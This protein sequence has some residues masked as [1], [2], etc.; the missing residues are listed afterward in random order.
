[1]RN[2]E[3]SEIGERQKLR[4]AT[5]RSTL[6][7]ATWQRCRVHV[8]RDVLAHVPKTA[9][10]MVAAFSRTVF[11]QPD[12]ASAHAQLGQVVERLAPS[13]PKAAATLLAEYPLSGRVRLV[14]L[15]ASGFVP[16]ETPVQIGLFCGGEVKDE[17][18]EK[19]D[20]AL[21]S[22]TEKFG[23][24]SVQRARLAPDAEPPKD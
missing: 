5:I 11:A 19:V 1:M 14:G 10:A 22:I 24:S 2:R 16:E 23:R 9:Q 12:P 17:N 20:R 6:L 8:L 7:G 15:G 3:I 18:W 13:F 4:S 21:D